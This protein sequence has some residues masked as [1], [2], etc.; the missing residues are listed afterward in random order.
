MTSDLPPETL[1]GPRP[2]ATVT[3][4]VTR[5]DD[6]HDEVTFLWRGPA[7]E[8]RVL[9]G[10]LRP[11]GADTLLERGP[12]L[13]SRAFRVRRGW[14]ASYRLQVDGAQVAD[15]LNPR[16]WRG[17]S[18]AETTPSSPW[19]V[20]GRR[21]HRLVREPAG[22]RY[23]PALPPVG[24]LVALDGEEWTDDLPVIL[25]NLIAAGRIPPVRAWLVESGPD[26]TARLT[27]DPGF[28][29]ALPHDGFT[30]IAGQSLG[31]LTAVYAAHRHPGRFAAAVSQSGSLWWPDGPE[32]EWLT[33]ELARGPVRGP[34]PRVHLQ[35][36]SLEGDDM[37]GPT[38]RLRAVL[39]AAADYRE[40]E[41]GH[42]RYCWRDRL[43]DALIAAFA[44]LRGATTGG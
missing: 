2:G 15:P 34:M 42:D 40:F 33:G 24:S 13:W 30:V 41:G 18:I 31:G 21:R 7:R 11:D 12:G 44:G 22:F 43:G 25:D 5:L 9:A 36:G 38:E 19:L 17:F 6:E 39:G 23:E 8:V 16:L 14:R 29:D 28:V 1:P 20:P 27:C 37:H 10:R 26:R 3:P 32:P 35:L 4:V